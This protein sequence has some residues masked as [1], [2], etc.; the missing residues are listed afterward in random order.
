MDGE[1]HKKFMIT[2]EE[3]VEMLNTTKQLRSVVSWT[4]IHQYQGYLDHSCRK[5]RLG[6]KVT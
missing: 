4:E 2:W 6:F 5:L 1:I 3:M